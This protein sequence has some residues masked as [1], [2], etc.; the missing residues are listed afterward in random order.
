MKK[1]KVK[2]VSENETMNDKILEVKT[3]TWNLYDSNIMLLIAQTEFVENTYLNP[4][5]FIF[6]NNGKNRYFDRYGKI[7]AVFVE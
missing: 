3:I 1:P 4:L 2:L 7:E 6:N 5:E